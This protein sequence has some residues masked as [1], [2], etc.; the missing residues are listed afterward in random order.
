I[1]A[2]GDVTAQIERIKAFNLSKQQE[3]TVCLGAA[4]FAPDALLPHPVCAECGDTGLR[5]GAV[6]DCV[7]AIQRKLLY[8]RLG[9]AAPIE[10]CGFERFDLRYYSDQSSGTLGGFSARAIMART[11]AAC[12]KYAQ[13]FSLASQ[14]LLL[15]GGPGLGKTH[16]SLSIGRAVIDQG[17]DALYVP[18]T[19][20]LTRLEAARFGKGSDEYLHYLSA[21]VG[22]EL[23]VLDDL[24]SEFSTPFGS[25]VLYDLINTRL[26][27][28][29]PTVISTNL[30]DDALRTRY[31]DRIASRLL[32]CYQALPFVGEDIRLLKMYK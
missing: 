16:L 15:T 18:F 30:N 10:L 28:G 23:L 31:S 14:S 2:G 21:P 12:Q 25:A 32:G 29:L 3:L 11:F 27:R 6:C 1:L 19:S 8:D 9:S 24:G 20:L 5:G 7:R 13:E 17:F 22:C 4:G 26:N